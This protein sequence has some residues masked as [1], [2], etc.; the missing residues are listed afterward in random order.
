MSRS[1]ILTNISRTKYLDPSDLQTEF[2]RCLTTSDLVMVGIGNMVG[3]GIY[4]LTG[5]VARNVAGPSIILSYI[6]AGFVS[7][8]AAICYAEF[9]ARVPKTGSAFLYAYVTIGE[10]WAFLIGWNLILE[11]IVASAAVASAWSGSID[12]LLGNQIA[13]FTIDYV[14][15]GEAWES[16]ILGKY[17]DFVACSI[18]CILAVVVCTGVSCS[19][20]AMN[21][22]VFLNV[23]IVIAMFIISLTKADISNFSAEGGFFPFGFQGVMAGAATCFFAFVG[24][25]VIAL[26][27]EEA[28]TPSKSM[29]VASLFSVG[30]VICL[31][32]LASITL[33]LLVPYNEVVPKAAFPAAFK[34]VGYRWAEYV[35]GIGTLIGMSSTLLGS[36]FALPRSVYAMAIEGLLFPCFAVVS[37]RTQIPIMAILVFGSLSAILALLFDISALVEFLSIGTLMAYAMVAAAIIVVRYKPSNH[38]DADDVLSD[39]DTNDSSLYTG[40]FV[41]TERKKYGTIKEPFQEI[42]VISNLP[43]GRAVC[44]CYFLSVVFQFL[45]VLI[46]ISNDMS[47]WWAIMLALVFAVLAILTF[48]PIPLHNQNEDIATFKVPFVPYFPA[49]SVLFDIFL[50]VKLQA[51]TWLRFIVWVTI[52]LLIYGFYGYHH[53]VEGKKI[54]SD[55]EKKDYQRM[56]SDPNPIHY[57]TIEMSKLSTS[58]LD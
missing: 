53:S 33:I 34:N 47:N 48:I 40:S 30:I 32:V 37:K 44:I 23:T 57:G 39:S 52:G 4:V 41:P 16:P 27:A 1:K 46:V 3:S 35:I 26:A 12:Q 24:F 51:L 25:D 22:F 17:P 50:L 13:N 21:S 19:S 31:Y 5:E 42:P 58:K 14:L 11:Y 38:Q 28:L 2:K 18:V 43:P 36:L 6:I 56:S 15:N 7:L 45:T 29:P 49:L 54:T 9:G 8:M 20:K 10:V 55:G